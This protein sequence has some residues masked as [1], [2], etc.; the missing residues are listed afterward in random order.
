M[1]QTQVAAN[2]DAVQATAFTT[3]D[4]AADLIRTLN[5]DLRLELDFDPRRD[6]EWYDCED[7]PRAD[8]DPP[9]LIQWHAYHTFYVEPRR[10]TATLIDPIVQELVAEGWTT[11]QESKGNGGRSVDLARDGYNLK[12]G[13]VTE[14][15]P[16][17]VSTVGIRVFS[18]CIEAPEGILDW[19][20]TASPTPTP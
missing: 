12:V 4:H 14:G 8:T 20:P 7:E 1:N 6:N 5:P 11:G 2:S 16:D 9:K 10:E 17:R 15:L 13:G 3:A 19:K 18:P